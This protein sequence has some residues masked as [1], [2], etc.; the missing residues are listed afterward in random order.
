MSQYLSAARRL[1]RTNRAAD[2]VGST[3]STLNKRRVKGLPPAF[4][5]LGKTVLYDTR[6]L[7]EWLA[8]CRRQS[9]SELP[10]PGLS[11]RPRGPVAT[12]PAPSTPLGGHPGEALGHS[13][14]ST[15]TASDVEK[16]ATSDDRGGRPCVQKSR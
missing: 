11:P 6:D 16:T 2:Y 4:I 5:K 9:T 3:E 10:T 14:G 12:P 1:L 15:V 7:D 8:S 13:L